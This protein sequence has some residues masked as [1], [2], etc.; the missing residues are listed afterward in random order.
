M[1]IICSTVLLTA[2]TVL[3]MHSLHSLCSLCSLCSLYTHAPYTILTIHRT[4]HHHVLRNLN[5]IR[6][7]KQVNNRSSSLRSIGSWGRRVVS[8]ASGEMMRVDYSSLHCTS[9]YSLYSLHS[10]HSLYSLHSLHSLHTH[11]AL[12]ILAHSLYSLYSLHT[13]YAF[14]A[15]TAHSLCTHYALTMHSLYSLY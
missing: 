10:L 12:A 4:P 6:I 5:D 8:D 15:L 2:L 13:H 9:L 11:Y 3:T 7:I 14:T 1:R